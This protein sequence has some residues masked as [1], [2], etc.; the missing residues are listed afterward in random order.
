MSVEYSEL[1]AID[2]AFGSH[3]LAAFSGLAMDG[4]AEFQEFLA[5]DPKKQVF[6]HDAADVQGFLKS[7]MASGESVSSIGTDK[8]IRTTKIPVVN[9]SRQPGLVSDDENMG[10]IHNKLK[11]LFSGDLVG[12]NIRVLSVV[13]TY[14]LVFITRDKPALDKFAL[15][16]MAH[17]SDTSNQKHRFE[18][19]YTIGGEVLP[20]RAMIKNP[21]MC[22]FDNESITSET[23]HF[24]ALGTTVEV[25]TPVLFGAAVAIHDPLR[26]E[27]IGAVMHG[28]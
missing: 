22:S 6:R 18:S 20:I 12:L 21:K 4:P 3:I 23:G 2:I 16:W 11:V 1:H 8:A 19:H 17:T 25:E 13:L 15:A 24:Y 28:A 5:R 7:Y 27:Y 26:I 10:G 14:R 9:Y